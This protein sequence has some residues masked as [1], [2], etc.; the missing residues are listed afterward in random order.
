MKELHLIII[1]EKGRMAQDRIVADIEEH[2]TVVKRYEVTWTPELV[3]R[4]FSRFYGTN[5][6]PNSFK[7]VECGTGPFLLFIVYD[8]HPV[9]QKRQTSRGPE[10]VDVNLFDAKTRYREWTQGGHKIHATNTPKETNHDLTLLFGKNTEDFLASVSL[11]NTKQTEMLQQDIVGANAWE[12]LEQLFYVLNNTVDYVILRGKKEVI[13]NCF[14]DEHRDVDI[15][16]NDFN[17]FSAIQIINGVSA[18]SV[19]R[20]HELINIQGYDYFLDMWRLECYYFDW[21]WSRQILA[22]R[23]YENKIYVLDADNEFYTLLYHCLIFKGKIADDYRPILEQ[24]RKRLGLEDKDWESILLNFLESHQ[25]DI[26]IPLD[27]SV[28]LH[29]EGNINQFANRHGRLIKYLHSSLTESFSF[30]SRVYEKDNSFV[31]EGSMFLI[32]NEQRFLEELSDCDLFPRIIRA[33]KRD[34]NEKVLEITRVKGID[35]YLFFDDVVHVNSKTIRSFINGCITLL[36]ILAKHDIIHRDWTPSNLLC[37]ETDSK[38]CKVSMIDFGWAIKASELQTCLRPS[39]LGM[40]YALA[41]HY[42]DIYSFA[43]IIIRSNLRKMPYIRKVSRRLKAIDANIASNNS[44]EKTIR[45][46]EEL[47]HIR[48]MPKD[49]FRILRIR[50]KINRKKRR[51]I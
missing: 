7:E 25:Y 35:C 49:Y 47:K 19:E 10:T 44:C 51:N 27:K 8:E 41:D 21:E 45:Q 34:N 43:E 1:W 30:V 13:S 4:N 12:S 15:F 14:P 26:T 39:G 16:L 36:Q 22:T 32:E 46:L 33:E 31:K 17:Y 3:A 2:F 5:L 6:P 20:P 28:G 24:H 11:S 42:S 18:C 29:L 48:F 37:Q 23:Q 38:H 9:Y 50:Y 40:E